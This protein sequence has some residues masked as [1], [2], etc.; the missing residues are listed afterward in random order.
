MD[1]TTQKRVGSQSDPAKS[2]V[3]KEELVNTF[4]KQTKTEQTK[5]EDDDKNEKEEGPQQFHVGGGANENE[6]EN[7]TKRNKID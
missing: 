2:A 6:Y 3:Q 5:T 1:S 7:E 4:S